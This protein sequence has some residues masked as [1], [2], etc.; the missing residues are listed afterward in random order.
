[1]DG[2]SST[3]STSNA[4]VYRLSNHTWV[5]LCSQTNCQLY[6]VTLVSYLTADVHHSRRDTIKYISEP[7][8]H[9]QF[10]A[11]MVKPY[12]IYSCSVYDIYGQSLLHLWLVVL[13]HSQVVS[14]KPSTPPPPPSLSPILKTVKNTQS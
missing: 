14:A 12:Y 1:M 10:I 11:F 4:L 3:T 9:S 5:L 2:I 6:C 8:S 13:F 7:Y